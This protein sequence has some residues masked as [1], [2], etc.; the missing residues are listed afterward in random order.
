MT[1][2]HYELSDIHY[3]MEELIVEGLDEPDFILLESILKKHKV[4]IEEGNY[5]EILALHN[6]ITQIVSYLKQ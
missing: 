4:S 2:L 6:K 3:N 5:E 1:T